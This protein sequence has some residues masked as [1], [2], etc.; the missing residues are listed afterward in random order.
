MAKNRL[1]YRRYASKS[2]IYGKHIKICINC[3]VNDMF[4]RQQDN[5]VPALILVF[6]AWMPIIIK[7][8]ELIKKP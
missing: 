6:F 3:M 8:F 5:K 1:F 2:A 4:C 7:T